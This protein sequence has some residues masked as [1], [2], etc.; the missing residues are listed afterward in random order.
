M[1][2]FLATMMAL[3]LAAGIP[4]AALAQ[5]GYYTWSI[6]A[7][8]VD[9]FVNS[10]APPPASLATFYL[11]F[12]EG[13]HPADTG[14]MASAEFK[15]KPSAAWPMVAII[16]QNGFLDAGPGATAAGKNFLLAVG[17]CPVGPVVAAN[18]LI[19]TNGGGGRVGFTVS[20]NV[21]GLSN[22]NGTVDCDPNPSLHLWPEFVRCVGFA[23]TDMLPF[24][25]HGS[26]CTVTPVEG[27]S[28]G[29]IKGLYR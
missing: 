17:S 6:S 16:P 2:K 5:G 27:S 9:P 29:Q 21:S 13:C 14:G 26:G 28:W 15:V 24:Q 3:V 12:V 20:D 7:S 23:T 11:W 8:N 19:T 18:L 1:N 22:Q 4:A 25:S 10:A